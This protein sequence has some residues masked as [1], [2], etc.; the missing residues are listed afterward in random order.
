MVDVAFGGDGAT[1]PL[2]LVPGVITPN[3]GTQELRLVQDNIPFQVDT[4]RKLWI[5]QYRNSSEM[6]WNSFY[7]FAELEFLH[8]DFEV[9]NWFTSTSP[10]SFQTYTALVV[11]FLR[12]KWT[13][14][15]DSRIHGKVMLVNGD[16]KMNEGGRTRLVQSCRTEDE[17]VAALQEFFSI[18]LTEGER[19]GIKGHVSELKL[20]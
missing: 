13:E 17:R 7:S 14:E 4:S 10:Q 15:D 6:E 8:N 12:T 1:K 20:L 2:P 18:T 5:Y 19:L 11:K 16:I 9:M 3:I